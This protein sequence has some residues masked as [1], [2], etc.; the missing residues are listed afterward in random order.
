[1]M[2]IYSELKA[3]AQRLGLGP[4][5]VT[6]ADPSSRLAAYDRSD[7]ESISFEFEF[8]GSAASFSFFFPRWLAEGYH[9]EMGF[10]AREDR[11]LVI[12]PMFSKEKFARTS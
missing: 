1:M 11:L 9:G 5:A 6:T 12:I 4:T 7:N 3:E 8:K 10:L 2:D